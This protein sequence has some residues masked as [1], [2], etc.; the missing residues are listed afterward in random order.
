MNKKILLLILSGLFLS[1]LQISVFGSWLI[2]GLAPQILVIVVQTFYQER[3]DL[4]AWFIFFFVIFYDLLTKPRF[5]ALESLVLLLTLLILKVFLLRFL[6]NSLFIKLLVFVVI[7]TVN[8]VLNYSSFRF[9]DV[10]LGLLVNG[11]GLVFFYPLFY[12]LKKLLGG[13]NSSQLRLTI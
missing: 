7:S 10:F 4:T 8:H 6:K 2:F 5:F 1:L 13:Q 9:S 11:L 12:F 3:E